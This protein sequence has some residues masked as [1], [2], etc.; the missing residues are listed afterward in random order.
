SLL[1]YRIPTSLDT[2]ELTALIGESNDPN[3]PHGAKEAGEGPL[4]PV[5][6]AISNAIYD[7]VGVRLTDVPFHPGMAL[8]LIR[9]TERRAVTPGRTK[10]VPEAHTYATSGTRS[11]IK[12]RILT[13]PPLEY[14][15]PSAL[16]EAVSLLSRFRGQAKV[17][18][19]GTDLLPN[20][21]HRLF[22]PSHLVALRAIRGLDSIDA[23]DGIIRL[24]AMCTIA[25]L[26]THPIVKS[27]LPS[28]ADAASQIA[29]PHLRE[30]A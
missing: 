16:E 20:M 23:E 11:R 14:H 4:H 7:A 15:A 5:I 9:G 27:R 1:D 21:K 3:G 13:L 8:H 17:I 2:P 19:G 26:A 18:A 12:R 29:G 24:G 6:P 28:L 30:M 22:T 10:R 25:Q